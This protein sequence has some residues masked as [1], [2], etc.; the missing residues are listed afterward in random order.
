M[1]KGRTYRLGSAAAALLS[2]S[3]P[4]FTISSRFA[5][6]PPSAERIPV[7]FVEPLSWRINAIVKLDG[8]WVEVYLGEEI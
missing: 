7:I 6:H 3:R 8:F 2:T 1:Q 4:T 5:L